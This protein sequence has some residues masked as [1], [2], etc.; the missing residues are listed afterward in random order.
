MVHEVLCEIA[1][2]LL[3]FVPRTWEEEWPDCMFEAVQDF[4]GREMFLAASGYA[5]D[6]SHQASMGY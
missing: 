4:Q 6:S 1:S 5:E 3:G 2:G